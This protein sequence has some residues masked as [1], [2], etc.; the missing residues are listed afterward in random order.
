MTGGF[1]LDRPVLVT[2]AT[3]LLGGWLTR[4]LVEAGDERGPLG[5]FARARDMAHD[6]ME[7]KVG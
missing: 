3:G 4:R 1:W 6:R 5:P 2:G 7:V